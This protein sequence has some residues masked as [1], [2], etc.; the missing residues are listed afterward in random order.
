M[1][2]FIKMCIIYVGVTA[3]K[4][5]RKCHYRYTLL[6]D[7]FHLALIYSSIRNTSNTLT[8]LFKSR[9]SEMKTKEYIVDEEWWI[10][11]GCWIFGGERESRI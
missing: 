4:R 2:L 9:V 10:Q 5:F 1:P 11:A 7:S 3:V 6:R 8:Y